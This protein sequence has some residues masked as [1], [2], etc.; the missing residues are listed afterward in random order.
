MNISRKFLPIIFSILF[1][2]GLLGGYLVSNSYA[3]ISPSQGVSLQEVAPTDV[4]SA[5]V[6]QN[7][8]FPLDGFPFTTFLPFVRYGAGFIE[9]FDGNPDAPTP[10]NSE[11]WDITVHSRDVSKF[12]TYNEMDAMHGT[13]CEPPM[14]TH[15]IS[16]YDDAVFNCKNHVMTA[17]NDGG[18]GVIYMTPNHLVDFSGQEAVVRFNVSTLRTSFRDWFDIR[19]TPFEDNLQLALENWLPDLSGEPRR[20]VHVTL[21]GPISSFNGTVIRNFAVEEL[22]SL[23]WISYDTF[24]EPSAT[25]RDLFELRI[26]KNHLQFGM[27]DYNFWWIDTEINPPLDWNQAV[28]QLG[29]HSYNP[30]KD[31]PAT[32]TPDTWH[33]DNVSIYPEKSFTLIHATQRYVDQTSS[34][35]KVTFESAAPANAYLRFTGIG[36]NLEV[37]FNNGVTWQSAQLQVVNQ[38]FDSGTFQSYW[39]PIPVGTSSVRFRGSN[40]W[41]SYWHV[42]DMSI[43]AKKK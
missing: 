33:W 38:S 29:H 15:L 17:I 18:Y 35:N 20:G 11:A 43:W 28:L 32:C 42:R 39:M 10:W 37:S 3:Q 2:F 27:P 25:R 16:T 40:G 6:S 8:L 31:C 24:L 14:A 36:T 41:A 4:C 12:Y 22:D 13:G 19:L 30:L 7:T 5:D 1:L 9:T 26:S 34:S 21:F 23:S